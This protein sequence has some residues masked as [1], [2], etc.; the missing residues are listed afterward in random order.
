VPILDGECHVTA[1]SASDVPGQGS[2]EPVEANLPVWVGRDGFISQV[3]A[4]CFGV[5]PFHE[6]LDPD[7]HCSKDNRSG[8]AGFAG[9]IVRC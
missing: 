9:G 4:G 6:V 1:G 7:A 3:L 5:G 2:P 8:V